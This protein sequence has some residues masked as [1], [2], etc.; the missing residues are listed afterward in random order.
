MQTA[1]ALNVAIIGGGPGCRAIMDMIFAEKLSGL[2]MNLIGVAD[3]NPKAAGYSYA[4]ERNIYTTTDY[5]DLFKL[6]DLNMIIEVT[7]NEALTEEIS[8]TKPGHVHLIDHVAA[9]VFWDIFQIE[10]EKVA[11]AARSQEG[12]RIA[13]DDLELRV[14]KRTAELEKVNR[15]CRVEIQKRKDIEQALQET[16]RRQKAILDNIPDMA[17]L[18][19]RNARFIA[20]NEPFGKACGVDPACMVGKTD[21]DI[22]PRE[23]A[24]TYRADD[25]EVLLSGKRKQVEEP[26]I[27]KE[28][29]TIWV[30]T[31]RTPI[32]D[33][34]RELIGTTGISRD[35]TN[36]KRVEAALRESERKYRALFEESRDAIYITARGGTFLDVNQAAL[37]LFGYTREEMIGLNAQDIY[38]TPSDRERYQREIERKGSVRDY[39]VRFRKKDGTAMDCLLTGNVRRAADGAVLGYQGMIRDITEHKRLEAQLRQSQKMEAI[40]T[41]A[42]GIAHDFNNLLTAI[43]GYTSLAIMKVDEAD[44]IYV[45]LKHVLVAAGRAADLTRQL[46]LFSRKQPTR[47]SP[48]NV[49]AVVANMLKILKRLIGEDIVII[50]ELDPNLWTVQADRG[51]IEQVIMNIAVNAR[52][53]MPEGGKLLIRTENA[54]LDEGD[55]RIIAEARTGKFVRLSIADT[56]TGMPP[57]TVH[58]M[59]E[60]FFSTKEPGKGTG[61]GL[62]VVYGIVKQH[63]GFIHVCSEPCR[64]STL[65]VYLPFFLG[66]MTDASEEE[67]PAAEARGKGER[68]L[69]VEDEETVRD[70]AATALRQSGYVVREAATAKEAL[71]IFTEESGAFDLVFS[72]VVLPQES[73]VQ[74]VEELL[75]RNPALPVLLTSGYTDDKSQWAVIRE[76]GFSFLHKP[77]AVSDLL[78]AVGDVLKK[79]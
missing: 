23:L 29:R 54:I 59:F 46:L 71:D 44:P 60:P 27:D 4:R 43:E 64:G 36:R 18:K 78:G 61:L 75:S 39:E 25:E 70:F 47:P 48:L 53:A 38:V 8:R 63:G 3:L 33:D 65:E 9:R 42:G 45:N 62:A 16:Q 11:Q 69:L 77:Y 12:L 17:W 41:L 40:G 30:E 2:R 56:G 6:K 20:A 50:P 13:H 58:H 66:H 74:L 32:Y 1:Q 68:V 51:N 67:T 76:K 19:D 28:G 79:T 73:G 21:F 37:D 35:I 10:E 31:I 7:G 26:L 55:C 72:D 15:E 57:D 14:Q 52:D 5:R 49:N 22:W 24:E 34:K